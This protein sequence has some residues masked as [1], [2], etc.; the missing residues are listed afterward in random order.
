M[1]R[2]GLV[3]V[4]PI[5]LTLCNLWV[6]TGSIGPEQVAGF[7]CSGCRGDPDLVGCSAQLRC[8]ILPCLSLASALSSLGEDGCFP[9]RSNAQM[10]LLKKKNHHHLSVSATGKPRAR[11]FAIM[12]QAPHSFS[13]RFFTFSLH[14]NIYS[15]EVSAGS[16]D[17]LEVSAS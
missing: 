17:P 2:F 11:P 10:F 7:V 4:V 3:D 6:F 13:I 16:Q 12:H 1:K 9:P 5:A 15:F 8:F 14:F